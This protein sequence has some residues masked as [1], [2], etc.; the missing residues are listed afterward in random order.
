MN[1]SRHKS[2][3]ANPALFPGVCAKFRHDVAQKRSLNGIN[4]DTLHL[5]NN[6]LT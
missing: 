1:H 6:W 2:S 5:N 4:Y 3:K